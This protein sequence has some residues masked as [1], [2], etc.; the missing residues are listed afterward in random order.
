MR[1]HCTATNPTATVIATGSDAAH[2]AD[3]SSLS[4]TARSCPHRACSFGAGRNSRQLT[5]W[6]GDDP[7]R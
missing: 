6:I 2:T 1:I 4:T 5:L 7:A 3:L